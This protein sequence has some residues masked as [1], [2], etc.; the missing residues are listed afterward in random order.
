[1]KII[2]SWNYGELFN[3]FFYRNQDPMWLYNPISLR[4]LAGNGAA[5]TEFGF[6]EAEFLAMTITDICHPDDLNSLE[7][8]ISQVKLGVKSVVELRHFTKSGTLRFI[9]LTTYPTQANEA[10]AALLCARDVTQKIEQEQHT[11]VEQ[12]SHLLTIASRSGRLGGWRVDLTTMT[13]HWSEQTAAIHG[14]SSAKALSAEE[15]INFYAPEYRQLV[16]ERFLRCSH[17]GTGFDDIFQLIDTNNRRFWVR[18]IGEAEYDE[19][20]TIIAVCGAFQDV[21]ELIRTQDSLAEVQQNLYDTL[22]RI[23]D[24]FFLLDDDWE[25]TYINTRAEQMLKQ[26]KSELLNRNVW[27]CFPDAVGSIF[28]QQYQLA[29]AEEKTVRFDAFFAP[30]ETHFEVSAYPMP[31]GLAVYFRDITEKIELSKQ[32]ERSATLQRHAHQLDA[33][34]KL[35]GGIAHDFNNLL[36]VILSNTELL[37]EHLQ[38]QPD[39]LKSANLTLSATQKA[40]SLVHYL[41]AFGRQQ[42]LAPELIGLANLL[43][44]T[45]A[46]MK[47]AIPSNIFLINQ[48]IDENVYIEIDKT[49][50]EMAMLHIIINAKEAMPDGGVVSLEAE[51]AA[52]L[53]AEEYDLDRTKKYI[54]LSISNTGNSTAS[55]YGEK[56]FQPFFTTK[57]LGDGFGLGLSFVHGFIQQSGGMVYIDQSYTKGFRICLLLPAHMSAKISGED[58]SSSNKKRLLLV[59]DDELLMQHLCTILSRESYQVTAVA[60]ADEAMALVKESQFDILFSD[61]ITP[62]KMDGIALAHHAKEAIPGIKI[63]L[64]SGYFDFNAKDAKYQGEFSFITK[65]YKTAEL[66]TKLISL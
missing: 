10:G 45:E 53:L 34:A 6:S 47:H 56:V 41:L 9:E 7:N 64:N 43:V 25:F 42:K 13:A 51:I 27:E 32:I 8:I 1:M 50:F 3:S 63:L 36:T 39:L 54:Q 44:N 28:E 55:K 62:G 30:L 58:V 57:A 23:S 31:T 5:I 59:E 11:Q 48:P 66:L 17:Y 20:G 33:L 2:S 24:A 14:F 18:A 4:Y 35:T 37:M 61:I 21:D 40:T 19:Q 15:A 22:E 38:Q 16:K 29:V 60:S 52:P 12:S 65:P 26:N 46:L 49:Q